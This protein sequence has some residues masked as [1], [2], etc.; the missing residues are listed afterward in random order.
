MIGL[1]VLETKLNYLMCM[2]IAGLD[3]FDFHDLSRKLS[4]KY[5][6][7]ELLEL[8]KN[9]SAGLFIKEI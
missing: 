7:D 6:R 9:E 3:K 1:R 2:D 5:V 4:N 8:W